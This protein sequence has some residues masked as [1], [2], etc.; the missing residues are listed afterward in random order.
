VVVAGG[1]TPI[2]PRL[3]A[4]DRRARALGFADLRA[5]LHARYAHAGHSLPPLA[6]ELR[7]S[8]W[9]VRA[10]MDA[11]LVAR[12]PGPVAKDRARKA[13]SDRH[14]AKRAARLGFPDLGAY[15]RDRYARRAWPLPRLADELGVGTRVVARLLRDHG[16]TR[17]RATAA[18][19]AAGTRARAAL[20]ARRV[21][22]RR[23][24]LAALGFAD[25]AGYL[26]V[27]RLEQGW[28]IERIAAELRV[29]RRSL[30]AQLSALGVP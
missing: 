17:T 30:R 10:A 2:P 6:A 3:W 22:L 11:H 25:L 7:T 15:L 18:Q 28:P 12:L 1:F 8:V 29:D 13:A 26:R 9:L 20:A 14:A 19:A 23:A 21:A 4:L 16:V 24:R 5:Y 27:R